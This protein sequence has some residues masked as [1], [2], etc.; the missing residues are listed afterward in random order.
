MSN[1]LITSIER[2]I[3]EAKHLVDLG[4]ALSRLKNNKDFKA[5]VQDGYFE[6]E[7]VRLVHLK[8]SPEFQ[9]PERQQAIITQMDSIGNLVSYFTV[10]A[11]SANQ[12]A[13]AIEVDE[14][15]LL[16]LRTEELTN[17]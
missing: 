5:L 10:V 13:K 1:D 15:T 8:A 16:E 4:A 14:E 3:K 7:A 6:K 2:N 11:F 9:T 17:D 12:A